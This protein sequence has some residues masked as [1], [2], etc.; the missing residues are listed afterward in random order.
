MT[1]SGETR[2]NLCQR[3]ALR[4]ANGGFGLVDAM[5]SML[6]AAMMFTALYA[7]L[8]FGFRVIKMAREN[9]R[10]TQ[11]MLEK[12]ETIRLYTWT[13]VTN[14]GD[15]NL[16]TFFLPSNPFTVAYYS[17]GTNSSSS[18]VYTGQIFLEASGV[19]KDDLGTPTS[20]ADDMRKITIRVDWSSLGRTNRTRTMTTR[21]ARNGM[22]T[23]V[24]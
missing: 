2:M 4:R 21:V 15:T 22:Q 17:V 18:L 20:Y 10:A 13:Q 1:V 16:G 5:F 6:L 3:S 19:T 9:T 8:A 24:Y 14:Y 11:I 12:M 23:Y 7:G